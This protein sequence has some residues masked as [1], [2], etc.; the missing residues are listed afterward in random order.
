VQQKL[1]QSPSPSAG[2]LALFMTIS[3]AFRHLFVGRLFWDRAS[4][5]LVRTDEKQW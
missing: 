2:S 5:L 3:F 1:L 4:L